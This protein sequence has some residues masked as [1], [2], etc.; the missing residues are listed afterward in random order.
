[1]WEWNC[2]FA[3]RV[4]PGLVDR[5]NTRDSLHYGIAV[6][7]EREP[8][9]P[10]FPRSGAGESPFTCHILLLYLVTCT[11]IGGGGGVKRPFLGM[12]TMLS[13]CKKLFDQIAENSNFYKA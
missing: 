13:R 9:P 3:R 12:L 6:I 8:P 2:A 5:V 10:P 4:A 1:M 11:P 7:S